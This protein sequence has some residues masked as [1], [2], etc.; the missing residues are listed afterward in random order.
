MG[1]CSD[2]STIVISLLQAVTSQHANVASPFYGQHIIMQTFADTIR[3]GPE[4]FQQGRSKGKH[5]EVY[6]TE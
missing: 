6:F 1:L 2:V 3:R 4:Y 5:R